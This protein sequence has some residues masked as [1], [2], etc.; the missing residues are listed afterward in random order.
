VPYALYSKTSEGIADNSVTSAKIV[1]GTV[2]AA[3]LAS[4]SVTSAKITDATVAAADLAANAVTTDKINTGAVI[5]SKID[6]AGA[7]SGQALKWN[8]TTWAPGNDLLGVSLWTQNGSNIYYNAGA[9]GIGTSA[10]G[11]FL[12]ILGN[13]NIGLPHLL[14]TEN[15]G[16]YARLSFKN[17]AATTKNWS[18]AGRPDPTDVNSRLNFWYWNGSIGTDIISVAGGGTVTVGIGTSAPGTFLQVHSNSTYLYGITPVIRISDNFKAWNIGLGESGDRFTIASE[19]LTER[20]T[21]LKSNG[22]VGIGT[23]TPAYKLDVAGNLNIIKGRYGDAFW[24]N[25]SQALWYDG[26]YFSWGYG[27]TYNYFADP[28]TIG[29]VTNPTSYALWVQGNAWS[30]GAFLSSDVRYKK[31]ISEIENPLDKIMKIRG[32]SFEFRSDEFKDYQFADG[33]QFGFIAQELENVFPEVVKT[34][35]DGYKSVN[36]SG[37]IPV[38][39]ESIKEQQLQIESQQKQIDELKQA[40]ELLKP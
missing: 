37:M 14:L 2:V 25:G 27:G 6:Q 9:V 40:V 3:D 13:S 36:Y 35:S 17:T 7:T 18:I 28:I 22:N 24:C 8:G 33:R 16:D 31:N 5:G 38:L 12:N 11:G 23:T 15:E 21:I 29:N 1:D 26:T 34:E 19:D 39:L 20:L 4:N 30:T 10:P 32:T